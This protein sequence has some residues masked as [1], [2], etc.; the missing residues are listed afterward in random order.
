MILT[1]LLH[2]AQ[3]PNIF[4]CISFPKILTD[5]L[6]QRKITYRKW[7][8]N[9]YTYLPGMLRTISGTFLCCRRKSVRTF[10]KRMVGKYSLDLCALGLFFCFVCRYHEWL[11]NPQH[12]RKFK[13]ISAN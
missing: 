5:F 12:F 11:E 9:L 3:K 1:N 7:Y 10:G 8:N 6:G 13:S 4:Q 2:D